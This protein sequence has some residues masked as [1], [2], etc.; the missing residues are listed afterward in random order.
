MSRDYREKEVEGV[1][2]DIRA[3]LAP[4]RCKV[5]VRMTS[6]KK[7][8]SLSLQAYNILIEIPLESVADIIT[9]AERR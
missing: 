8:K 5:T 2:G 6:D 4:K 1:I 7:G 9:L 3:M